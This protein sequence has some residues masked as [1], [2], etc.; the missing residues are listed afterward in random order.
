MQVIMLCAYGLFLDSEYD[1]ILTAEESDA[2]HNLHTILKYV[3]DLQAFTIT[4][5]EFVS[6][7]SIK[8][9]V[10]QTGTDDPKWPK[11]ALKLFFGHHKCVLAINDIT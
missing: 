5:W 6:I 7:A 11:N 2:S 4:F 8:Y 1:V 3:P 9:N 10:E